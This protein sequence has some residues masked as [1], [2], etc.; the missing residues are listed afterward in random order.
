M[1]KINFIIILYIISS[2]NTTSNNNND[3]IFPKDINYEEYKIICKEDLDINHEQCFSLSKKYEPEISK[4]LLPIDINTLNEKNKEKI[5]F[6]YY[7]LGNIYYHGFTE[8]E[9]DLNNGLIYFIISAFFGS[10]QSKYKLSIILSNNIFEQIYNDKKFQ[11]LIKNIKIFQKIK[12]TDYY[13][14]NFE[15]LMNEYNRQTKK[16]EK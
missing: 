16:G 3:F 8:K 11:K 1:S 12:N 4:L 2:I 9:P 7:N 15:Y 6:I 14:K 5:S 10:P 13:I